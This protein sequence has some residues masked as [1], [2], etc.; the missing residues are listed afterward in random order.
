M[1]G[2]L[3]AG[4]LTSPLIG[5][6]FRPAQSL[7]VNA[8]ALYRDVRLVEKAININFNTVDTDYSENFQTFCQAQ[9]IAINES[10][11]SVRLIRLFTQKI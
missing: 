6:V 4:F 7:P 1:D 11:L 2:L 10:Q 9:N 8:S 5:L 3:N